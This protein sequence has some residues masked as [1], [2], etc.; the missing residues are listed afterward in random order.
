MREVWE[1]KLMSSLTTAPVCQEAIVQYLKRGGFEQHLRR[2][3]Q[4]LSV[5]CQEMMRAV[6]YEFPSDCRMTRPDG[7]YMLWVEMPES[8]DV[9]EL[10][11]RALTAAVSIL[12]GPIFSAQRNYGNFMRLNFGHPTVAQIRR[13]VSMLAR[14]IHS[15][16]ANGPPA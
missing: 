14:L 6:S 2:L 16:A 10:Y 1:S 12:P 4:T 15:T 9:L 11:R 5:R 7:G 13:G 3:R 8:V